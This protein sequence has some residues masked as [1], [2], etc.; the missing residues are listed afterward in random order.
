MTAM[1]NRYDR[2]MGALFGLAL[3]DALGT[4]L[5]FKPPGT[6]A[7]IADMIGGGPFGLKAGEWTDDTS[8]AMCLAE[9]LVAKNGFDARDQMDRYRQWYRAGYWSC[10]DHCFDIGN[11]VRVAIE[12][13][14]AIGEPFA[15]ATDS[16]TAGNGALMRL[17]P[18]PLFYADEPAKALEMARQ[19][20]RTTHQTKACLDA[21][22]Y[23]AGLII[24]ALQERPKEELLSTGFTPVKSFFGKPSYCPEIQTVANGSFKIKEPPAIRGTGYVVD[25]L[26]AAL[27]AFHKTNNF[28]DGAL[29]AANL[30]DDADT[31]AAIYGQIAGAYYGLGGL[32]EDWLA[33]LA[34]HKQIH[35]L[36]GRLFKGSIAQGKSVCPD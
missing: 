20:S 13:F 14:E 17:A 25:S 16:H 23:F 35:L 18:I 19:S 26:E 24:G 28:R 6:F 32:P 31:T 30:G 11:T 33:K 12:T 4:T 21:S 36:A 8:M 27:W 34:W 5:E 7:P 15:G 29:F 1:P 22:H 10:R 9:S 3:G 2:H